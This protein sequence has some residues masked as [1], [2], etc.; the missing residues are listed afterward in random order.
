MHALFFL[1]YM[2]GYLQKHLAQHNPS[3]SDFNQDPQRQNDVE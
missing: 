1:F 2:K 3:N